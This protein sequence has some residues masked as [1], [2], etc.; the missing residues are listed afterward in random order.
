MSATIIDSHKPTLGTA[1]CPQCQTLF[2][3]PLHTQSSSLKAQV[4]CFSC[5]SIAEID[6]TSF[7]D[8]TLNAKAS[9]PNG[10]NFNGGAGERSRRLGTDE[11]PVSTEYYDILGVAPTATA[12]EIKKKY[13]NLAM[14]YHPDKSQEADA[15]EKFKEISEAYQILSDPVLRKK[16]NEYGPQNN[17]TPEGGFADP[18]D[19]FRQQFGGDRFVDWIGE[20][21]IA[22]D[23]KEAIQESNP[24]LEALSEEEKK[25]R[26]EQQ[27]AERAQARAERVNRLAQNLISK[28]SMF[29]ESSGD[30]DAVN[31]FKSAIIHEANDLQTESYGV[32][33][34]HAIGYTYTLKSRQYLSRD[35]FLGI[36]RY[37]HQFREKSHIIGETYSTVK[38]AIDMQSTV[39]QLQEA[40]KKGL[41]GDA[42]TVLEE[43]A[44]QKGMHAIWR[45]SKLEVES[46]LRDVCDTVLRD[47]SCTKPVL[48]RRAQALKMVGQIF[49][50]VTPEGVSESGHQKSK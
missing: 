45:G 41:D 16:Y 14:K 12:G 26:E 40:D 8:N 11:K 50:K 19:M 21:S 25:K 22:R 6:V 34:L 48:K 33:L 44:A 5:S 39:T 1:R 43:Q 17:I 49:E 32:E 23:F 20:I 15:E 4:K 30:L 28:L 27:S 42:R 38:S 35:E 47:P 2:Q 7:I 10:N 46:V 9:S 24:E 3:F 36:G 37:F 13:Y 18:E 31:K 29:V